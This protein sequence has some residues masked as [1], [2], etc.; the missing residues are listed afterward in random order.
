LSCSKSSSIMYGAMST[1]STKSLERKTH[2][3]SPATTGANTT[4][5]TQSTPSTTTSVNVSEHARAVTLNSDH[6]VELR[7]RIRHNQFFTGRQEWNGRGTRT[8]HYPSEIGIS[9]GIRIMKLDQSK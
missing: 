9:R 1:T 3:S 7:W 6:Y 8:F 4:T 2:M 5:T